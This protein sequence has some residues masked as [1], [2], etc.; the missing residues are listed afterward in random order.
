VLKVEVPSNSSRPEPLQKP[1]RL[2]RRSRPGGA[3]RR[4]PHGRRLIAAVGM[5]G[6][7]QRMLAAE[8]RE[9]PPFGRLKRTF[10]AAGDMA[11]QFPTGYDNVILS[12]RGAG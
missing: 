2:L 7:M 4:I 6:L 12:M 5:Q 3:A 10:E 1:R 9:E 11:N 8:L